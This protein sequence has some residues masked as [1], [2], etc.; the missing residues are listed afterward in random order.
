MS[1]E[2]TGWTGLSRPDPH[3]TLVAGGSPNALQLGH[4]AL[5]QRHYALDLL[6]HRHGRTPGGGRLAADVEDVGATG[7]GSVRASATR[8]SRSP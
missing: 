1:T 3:P 5:D 7:D 8:S 4:D 6:R 2:T